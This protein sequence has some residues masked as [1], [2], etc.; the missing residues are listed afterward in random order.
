MTN[1]FVRGSLQPDPLSLYGLNA[2]SSGLTDPRGTSGVKMIVVN[3]IQNGLAMEAFDLRW[4][5]EG[6]APAMTHGERPDWVRAQ[7]CVIP[8]QYGVLNRHDL[9]D[10]AERPRSGGSWG[11]GR[12]NKGMSQQPEST[13]TSLAASPA[14]LPVPAAGQATAQHPAGIAPQRIPRWLERLELVLRVMLRIYIGLAICYAPWSPMFWDHNPLFLQFPTVGFIAASGAVRGIVSGLGLLNL[15][16]ALQ[17][18][19][20]YRDR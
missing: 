20:H 2:G 18:A 19:I 3:E 11:G 13:S 10:R 1:G 8:F 9:H 15:W 6:R 12:L 14:P 16:I 5:G 4:S 17:D 7:P